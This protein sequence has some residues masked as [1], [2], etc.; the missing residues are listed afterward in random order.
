MVSAYLEKI[1]FYLLI[2]CLPFQTRKI[3]YQWGAEFNEWSS[4]YLYLTDLLI[5]LIIFF[6]FWRKRKQ[7]FLKDLNVNW[8]KEKIKTPDF[9]LIVFLVISLISLVQARNI[10]LGFYHWFKLLEL[11][12][13][14]F[15]LRY[16]F[17]R[18]FRFERVAQVLVAS[19]FFQSLVAFGQYGSQKSLGLKFLR[20]SPLAIELAGVAKIVPDNLKLIRAYGT[21]P[22]ANLLA[23]FLLISIFFLYFLWLRKKYSFIGDCLLFTL[24]GLLIFS[25]GLTFSRIIIA[26]FLLASLVYFVF[27]FWFAR[28]KK[29]KKLS[30][31]VIFIFLFFVVLCSLFVVL[32]WPE[33]SSRFLISA[34]EQAVSLRAF[35]NQTAFSIIKEHPFLGIGLGNFVWEIKQLLHLLASWLHQP[36]HNIYLLIASETGLIGLVLFLVFIFELLKQLNEPSA[37]SRQQYRLLLLIVF[38]L[39]FIGLFDH[40][41]WTL[42]Q[43]QLIWWLVLGMIAS[44]SKR[45][46]P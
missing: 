6:W 45:K 38:C 36:V 28:K 42:Q 23:A 40:F 9:W 46:T 24:F 32:A 33:I 29:D 11:V 8:L 34:R 41:F 15:Y 26:T 22:H 30:Q 39:L 5:L 19:S 37:A 43:G 21:L 7:R 27:I 44:F 13:L 17:R 1:F 31:R 16:N 18:L 4:V 12:G 14:F 2:F 25:L 3:F 35:Y 10:Q 20:E